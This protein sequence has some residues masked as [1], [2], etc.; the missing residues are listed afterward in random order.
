MIQLKEIKIGSLSSNLTANLLQTVFSTIF[1]FILFRYVIVNLGAASF[2]IW[3]VV[4]ATVSTS[5]LF[6][7]GISAAVIRYVALDKANNN[8]SSAGET[9]QTATLGL[10][11][12][13]SILIPVLY[14]P[15]NY[16]FPVIF[17]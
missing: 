1:S 10:V 6:E 11:I 14:F 15:L 2:G 4:L 16:F 5:R 17:E 13:L 12:F 7:M 9:I 3:S 8:N